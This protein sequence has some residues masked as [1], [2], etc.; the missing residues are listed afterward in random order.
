MLRGRT[1]KDIPRVFWQ[2]FPNGNQPGKYCNKII[3][4]K[5]SIGYPEDF[6][7]E[8]PTGNQTRKSKGLPVLLGR[9]IVFQILQYLR[10]RDV[11]EQVP[12][13]FLKALVHWFHI[14]WRGLF[15]LQR[16]TTNIIINF[17]Q[18]CA[19]IRKRLPIVNC[20]CMVWH[21]RFYFRNWV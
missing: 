1:P 16:V 17:V 11:N 20:V 8:F 19:R 14:H 4:R 7:W 5:N 10:M 15:R 2:E 6:L 12:T 18:A 21:L 3:W 13:I 9:I